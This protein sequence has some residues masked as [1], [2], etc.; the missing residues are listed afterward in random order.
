[1]YITSYVDGKK[2]VDTL[3]AF[4]NESLDYI[5]DIYEYY[6]EKTGYDGSNRASSHGTW[7]G[8]LEISSTFSEESDSFDSVLSIHYRIDDFYGDD[9]DFSTYDHYHL[10]F[11][12]IDQ[13]F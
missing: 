13:L 4:S 2:G 6:Y 3:D 1:M 5:E 11:Q 9:Q 12:Q 10:T 8:A 7:W